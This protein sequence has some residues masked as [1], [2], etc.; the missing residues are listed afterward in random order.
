VSGGHGP[1]WVVFDYGEVLCA[2]TSALPELAATLGVDQAELEPQYWAHRDR[3]DRGASDGEYWR[4][5]GQSLGVEVGESTADALTAIDIEGWSHVEPAS[6][7][8]LGALAGAGVPLALLSNAPSSF[9]RFAERQA[10]ARHFQ[11]RVFSGDVGLA[12]PDPQIFELLLARL[13]A[14]AGECLFFDD[15]QSNV[16][17]ARAAGLPAHR[18]QGVDPARAVLY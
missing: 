1:G 8:L 9:A 12:K 16:D 10:W 13:D 17:G 2:R 5:V 11:V 6:V 4:G 18:W 15:R 7:D 14:R 3:Y